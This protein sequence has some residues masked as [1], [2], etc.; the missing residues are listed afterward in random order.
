MN[1]LS[2]MFT[3]LLIGLDDRRVFAHD[4]IRNLVGEAPEARV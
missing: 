2:A 4:Y 1:V 3:Q